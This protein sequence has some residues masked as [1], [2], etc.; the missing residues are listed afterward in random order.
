MVDGNTRCTRTLHVFVD[1]VIDG[2]KT[3]VRYNYKAVD[4]YLTL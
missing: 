4:L 3:L 2:A 1:I